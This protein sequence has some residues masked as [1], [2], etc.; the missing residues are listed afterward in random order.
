MLN[1]SLKSSVDGIIFKHVNLCD[2]ED[3]SHDVWGAG[4]I[5]YHVVKVDE[6]AWE[7]RIKIDLK[8]I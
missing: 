8:N 4:P 1:A 7:M 3:V 5:A 6:R 2:N